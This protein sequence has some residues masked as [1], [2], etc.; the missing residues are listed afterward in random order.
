MIKRLHFR[1]FPNMVNMKLCK[2]KA[3]DVSLYSWRSE[4]E[5]NMT[6]FAEGCLQ[7]LPHWPEVIGSPH[8]QKNFQWVTEFKWIIVYLSTVFHVREILR[9]KH[10]THIRCL[11]CSSYYHWS[12]FSVY[13]AWFCLALCFSN[14]LSLW[15][16]QQ[17]VKMQIPQVQSGA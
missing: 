11:T 9:G 2:L 6:L 16:F 8:F 7:R 13:L 12:C 4:W 5:V 15:V 3:L 17:S 1:E 10:S 14:L